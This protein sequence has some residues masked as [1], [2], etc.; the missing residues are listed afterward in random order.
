[1]KQFGFEYNGKIYMLASDV[2]S[3]A[4]IIKCFL[5]GVDITEDIPF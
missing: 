1:M 4:Q 2:W 3:K 5:N